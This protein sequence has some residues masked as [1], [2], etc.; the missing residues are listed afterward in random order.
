MNIMGGTSNPT[1]G[2]GSG[3]GDPL[4][5]MLQSGGYQNGGGSG[6]W[7]GVQNQPPSGTQWGQNQWGSYPSM[8]SNMAYGGGFSTPQGGGYGMQAPQSML[9]WPGGGQ[10]PQQMRGAVGQQTAGQ[11]QGGPTPFGPG[12]F[13]PGSGD[14]TGFQQ[15]AYGTGQGWQTGQP[16]AYGNTSTGYGGFYPNPQGVPTSVPGTWNA[17]NNYFTGS[18]YDPALTGDIFGYLQS[19]VGQQSPMYQGQLTAGPN[20]VLQNMQ[21]YLTGQGSNIP[22][23]NQLSNLA[24]TG[25]NI[26]MGAVPAQGLQQLGQTG[27]NI[28]VQGTPGYGGL[29][30]MQQTGGNINAANTA[31]FGG[32]QNIQQTGGNINLAGTPAYQNMLQMAQTGNPI[33]VT[34]EWQSMVAAMQQNTDQQAAQIKEQMSAGG[35]LV[36]TPYGNTMANFYE[37]TGL[38]QQAL[39]GQLSTQAQQQAVQNQLAA[40]GQLTQMGLQGQEAGAQNQLAAAGQLTGYGLQGQQQT[41][42]NQLAA[43]G[44]LSQLGLQGQEQNVANMLQALQGYGGMNIQGQQATAGNQ[45]GATGQILSQVQ[46]TSQQMQGVQQTGLSNAYQEWLRTQP[47]YNPLMSY[48]YGAGTTFPPYLTQG[49]SSSPWGGLAAAAGNV[50]AAAINRQGQGTNT[51]FNFNPGFNVNVGGN[52]PGFGGGVFGG[53][54]PTQGGFGGYDPSQGYSP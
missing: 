47:Q 28:G 43:S 46:P 18:T 30:T 13:G 20:Q 24:Q 49:A 31:G 27:G 48:M 45:L 21:G 22:G 9:S 50:A 15:P 40:Q 1:G 23:M 42:A 33:N 6:G 36:G 44:Q 38:N 37:Q 39:L 35:N 2:G 14:Q 29:Q 52:P 4:Q 17:G 10:N 3:T 16:N 54:D 8:G 19:Q 7:G 41:A 12:G 32:L 51:N 53:Y 5:S 34:P 25:G 11:P 26:N